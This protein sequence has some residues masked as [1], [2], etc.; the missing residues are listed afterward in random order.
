[1]RGLPTSVAADEAGQPSLDLHPPRVVA[2]WLV[3]A[4]GRIETDHA[5]LAAEGLE[6]RFLIVDQRHDDLPVARGIGLADERE[7]AVEN[8]FL[9]HRIARDLEAI[10]FAG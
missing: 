8:P 9:D 7:V 6:R 4:V 5:P 1:M 10:M 2:L 3:I